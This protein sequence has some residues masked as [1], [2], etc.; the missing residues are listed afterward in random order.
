MNKLCPNDEM[1]AIIKFSGLRF[2]K[3]QFIENG[4]FIKLNY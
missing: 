1:I 3:Q 4:I 2:L